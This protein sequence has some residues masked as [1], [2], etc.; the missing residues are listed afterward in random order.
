MN[1]SSRIKVYLHHLAPIGLIVMLIIII[2]SPIY[3]TAQSQA[4]ASLM[5]AIDIRTERSFKNMLDNLTILHTAVNTIGFDEDMLTLARLDDHEL[6]NNNYYKIL[7][8]RN[9]LAK[10][11][12][13]GFYHQIYFVQ[14]RENNVVLANDVIYND[15]EAAY[16]KHY[17]VGELTYNEWKKLSFSPKDTYYPSVKVMLNETNGDYIIINRVFSPLLPASISVSAFISVADLERSFE[18]TEYASNFIFALTDSTGRVLYDPNEIFNK[19]N[20]VTNQSTINI[21]GKPYVVFLR[22]DVRTP[23]RVMV[24]VPEQTFYESVRSVTRLIIIIIMIALLTAVISIIG[25]AIFF[26]R[27]IVNLSDSIWGIYNDSQTNNIYRRIHETFKNINIERDLLRKNYEETAE[28]LELSILQ[29]VVSGEE[30]LSD[31]WALLSSRH[32]LTGTYLLLLIE[33]Q[34]MHQS[35]R[36]ITLAAAKALLEDTP[37]IWDCVTNGRLWAVVP[38]SDNMLAHLDNIHVNLMRQASVYMS[39][40]RSVQDITITK[41]A[42]AVA[43]ARTALLYARL[44]PTNCLTQFAS[45][46]NTPKGQLPFRKLASLDEALSAANREQALQLIGSMERLV[47]DGDLSSDQISNLLQY[48]DEIICEAESR[49]S[50]LESPGDLIL[51]K[52]WDSIEL[53]S[54]FAELA[55]RVEQ[56]CDYII[57]GN[58]DSDTDHTL[59]IL[60]YIENHYMDSQLGLK[61]IAEAFSMSEKYVSMF[62][63]RHIGKTYT[64]HIETVRMTAAYR[65][66]IDTNESIDNIIAC[67]G[68]EYKNTFYKAFKRYWGRTPKEV[69]G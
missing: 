32:V 62:I 67:V 30:I 4:R 1:R 17:R 53:V 13:F 29:R 38:F 16:D 42:D 45:D 22:E 58:E 44:Q 37:H 43:E 12:S 60:Q 50:L 69:R 20:D 23:L 35:E 2:L 66:L 11:A 49:V 56:L 31:E 27:P 48:I 21:A 34:T 19:T 40:S 59:K 9:V 68:Y 63:K 39:V 15:K 10:Y 54:A 5:H 24:C 7:M 26:F 28:L 33:V 47:V 3:L 57:I 61:M 65:M 18:S 14:F 52:D 51:R 36:L 6:L 25:Y 46:Q 55:R 41:M 64:S 8:A